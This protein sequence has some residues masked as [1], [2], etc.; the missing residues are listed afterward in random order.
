MAVNELCTEVIEKAYYWKI[1]RDFVKGEKT[2]KD[3]GVTYLPTKAGQDPL[4]YESYKTRAKVGDYT[5]QILQIMTGMIERKKPVITMPENEKLKT[6]IDDFDNEGQSLYQHSVFTIH[7]NIQ[8]FFGGLLSDMPRVE[9]SMSVYEAEKKGYHPYAK[10]YAAE[11]VI[12]WKFRNEG[13]SKKLSLVV[14]K[15]YVDNE[16]ADEFSHDKVVQYRV[17]SLDKN[18]NYNVRLFREFDDEKNGVKVDEYQKAFYP[19]FNGECQTEIP[20]E[21]LPG[22]ENGDIGESILYG[23]AE[24]QRHYYMQ[25]ADYENGVHFTTVPTLWTTGHDI[26]ANSKDDKEPPL[27]LGGDV[28]LNLPEPDAKI[29][30]VQFAGEGL[31]HSRQA[32]E[33]TLAQIGILGSRSVSPDKNLSGSADAERLHRQGENANL[34]TYARNIS[35]AYTKTLKRLARYAGLTEEEIKIISVQFNVDYDSVAFDPNAINSIANLSR[36]GK[37]PLP[38]VY[39]ALKKGEYLPNELTLR[40]FM[41]LIQLEMSGATP[42]EELEIYQKMLAGEKINIPEL[43]VRNLEENFDNPEHLDN[44]EKTL[45]NEFE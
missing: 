23:V 5:K 10:Y 14:L 8:T 36:E 39:D 35:E 26:D 34:A 17:L 19:K 7:D 4:D 12:N 45:R 16:S 30:T 18:G 13:S 41:L 29:G 38:L 25:S 24:L 6:I 3:A 15:E 1:V 28:A 44:K 43:L 32:K 31:T 2:V 21:F 11:N 40:D 22:F 37:F 42:A 20:F 27:V 33:E 9:G